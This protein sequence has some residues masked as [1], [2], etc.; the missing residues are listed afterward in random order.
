MAVAKL[1]NTELLP[2]VPFLGSVPALKAPAP[3]APTV[4]ALICP[5]LTV[6]EEE[7]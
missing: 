6:T 3:P 5:V 7:M 2:L 4:I 1:A